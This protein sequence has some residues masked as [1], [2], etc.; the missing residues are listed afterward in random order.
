MKTGGTARTRIR[1][2]ET[3]AL[4][5]PE[6][7][8]PVIGNLLSVECRNHADERTQHSILTPPAGSPQGQW[9]IPAE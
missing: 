2:R 8:L 3:R 6:D 1:L 5:G 7:F 9:K 4:C